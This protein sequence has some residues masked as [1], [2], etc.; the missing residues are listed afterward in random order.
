MKQFYPDDLP[1]DKVM[2]L[3]NLAIYHSEKAVVIKI[4]LF[5]YKEV[6]E[7]VKDPFLKVEYEQQINRCNPLFL[8]FNFISACS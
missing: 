8:F 3:L 4:A 1:V 2:A 5:L 7:I 6:E